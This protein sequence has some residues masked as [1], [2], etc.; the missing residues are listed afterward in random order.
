MKPRNAHAAMKRSLVR[1][2]ARSAKLHTVDLAEPST[3]G[4]INANR[5]VG[6]TRS[7]GKTTTAIMSEHSKPYDEKVIGS[8][9]VKLPVSRCGNS[10]RCYG[11]K[12]LIVM[13]EHARVVVRQSKCF[14]SLTTLKAAVIP[15]GMNTQTALLD[16]CSIGGCRSKDGLMGT[17]PSATTATTRNIGW[18]N[19][20][21]MPRSN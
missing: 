9:T 10:R 15:N 3:P 6:P 13:A 8:I 16:G 20:P 18:G 17:K 12:C 1:S 11:S 7:N 21:I 14:S 19:V 5:N 2:S 4:N